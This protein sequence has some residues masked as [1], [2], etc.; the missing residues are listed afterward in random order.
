MT[1]SEFFT[2]SVKR[3]AETSNTLG[4]LATETN[5]RTAEE[6]AGQSDLDYDL[7]SDK[8]ELAVAGVDPRHRHALSEEEWKASEWF[9]KR[10][11]YA[12]NMTPTRARIMKENRDRRD[13]EDDLLAHE[14]DSVGRKALGF[15]AGLF[16]GLPDPVNLIPFGAGAK[17]LTIGKAI[18]HGMLAGAAGS[19]TADAIMLPLSHAQGEDVGFG[20]LIKD[21]IFG[22]VLGGG[23]GA[24]G[25]GFAKWL[26]KRREAAV[27]SV[28]RD[29]LAGELDR[30]RAHT[31][32]ELAGRDRFFDMQDID[33][34]WLDEA[35]RQRVHGP[36]EEA[37]G[38]RFLDRQ[39]WEMRDAA[40]RARFD[41][42]MA[43]WAEHDGL[44]Q[45][46]AD[47]E[48]ARLGDEAAESA[49]RHERRMDLVD[50]YV[51]QLEAAG[52]SREQAQTYGLVHAAH[53]E[54]MAPIF[55]ETPTAY[56][57]R[58]LSGFQEMT[59][60]EFKDLSSIEALW[61]GRTYDQLMAD[62]GV[63]PGM[64]KTQKRR[65]LSMIAPS[66]L[67]TRRRRRPT[68]RSSDRARCWT[69]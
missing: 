46:W 18:R 11:P 50:K 45:T 38:D 24:F 43:A 39:E 7:L 35:R 33:F 65:L 3:A 54:V 41:N 59:P 20:D 22:A 67:R 51:G 58:R 16:A 12:P 10:I 47:N 40:D 37:G 56:L 42:D 27:D 60:Q 2:R 15:A 6:A 9:D 28:V 30:Y 53:A 52:Y 4:H 63:K 57:E 66:I 62:M 69:R 48:L 8:G 19:V 17:G 49:N 13:A 34:R 5:I 32:F 21:S 26:G 55:G 68:M 23:F 25:Y 14:S 29:G 61:E 36:F 44:R 1:N 31:S 64:S